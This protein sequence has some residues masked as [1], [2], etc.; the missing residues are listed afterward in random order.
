MKNEDFFNQMKAKYPD[1][2]ES[3]ATA[4]GVRYRLEGYL[5]PATYDYYKN[6]H[7]LNLSN[8]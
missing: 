3:A 5:F 8:K 1:L 2:L 6:Q 4:E 7:F